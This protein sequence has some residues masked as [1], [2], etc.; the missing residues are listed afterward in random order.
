MSDLKLKDLVGQPDF[1]VDTSDIKDYQK[2]VRQ[3]EEVKSADTY[4]AKTEQVS[5]KPAT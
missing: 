5:E 3:L 2:T 4:V 1:K